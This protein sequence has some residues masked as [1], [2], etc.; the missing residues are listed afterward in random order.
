M[1]I[2]DR[3]IAI[4]RPKPA[5]TTWFRTAKHNVDANT[6]RNL[7]HDSTVL[8]LPPFENPKQADAYIKQIFAGI[9][10]SELVSWGL[11]KS[12]WPE[13]DYTRFSE[14]FGIEYHSV[15]FDV[16]FLGKPLEKVTPQ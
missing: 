5:L 10:E 15:V 4:L 2:V 9:F 16:A 6:L 11:D 7:Q 12:F 14:W 8:M 1:Y 13:I 3:I